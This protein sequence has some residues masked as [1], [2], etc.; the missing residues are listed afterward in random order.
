MARHSCLSCQSR[1]VG[2]WL[3]RR[4]L[5]ASTCSNPFAIRFKI[6]IYG[7]KINVSLRFFQNEGLHFADQAGQRGSPVSNSFE[8]S[9]HLSRNRCVHFVSPP[10]PW[11]PLS[12]CQLPILFP[13]SPQNISGGICSV[14]KAITLVYKSKPSHKKEMPLHFQ[15]RAP[16]RRWASLSWCRLQTAFHS[17]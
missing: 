11:S 5:L 2:Q 17:V 14:S 4:F 13:P 15:P 8:I 10:R 9:H 3:L 12:W 1:Y 7:Y 6:H 16:T